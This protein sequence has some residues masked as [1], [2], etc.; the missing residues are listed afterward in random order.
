MARDR[1][2]ELLS[3]KQRAGKYKRRPSKYDLEGLKRTWE[4]KLKGVDPTDELILIRIVT[5]LEVFL[6]LWIEALIDHG[7]PYVERAAKL[8]VDV[9]YDFAIA[10]SLQGGSVTLGELI[11]HSLSPNHIEFFSSVLG[12]LLDQDLFQAIL[13]TRDPWRVRHEGDAVGPIISDM[14]WVRKRLARLFEVRHILVHEIPAKKPHASDE[15]AE[16]IDAAT[17]FLHAIDM[18]LTFRLEGRYPMT[19]TEMTRDAGARYKAAM[20]ELETLCDEVALQTPGIHEVQRAWLPF[21]EAEAERQAERHLGGTIRPMLY[22]L[23]SEAITRARISKLRE[24]LE[25]RSISSDQR[26]NH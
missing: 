25:H 23:A 19:Q 8:R 16:F 7:A 24:W 4:N 6:R 2:T 17:M 1:I 15:V 9:K 5:I 22:F 11:A 21:K 18:E 14:P 3:I 26:V 13:N 20:D 10:Q 12:T